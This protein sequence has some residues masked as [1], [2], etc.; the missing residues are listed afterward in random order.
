MTD[1]YAPKDYLY[2]VFELVCSVSENKGMYT[3]K[4]F[5]LK[6]NYKI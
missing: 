1:T 3:F 2:C 5:P 6:M 4:S